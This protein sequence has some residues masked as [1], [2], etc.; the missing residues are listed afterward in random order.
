M[1]DSIRNLFI[2]YV[3]ANIMGMIGLSCYILADT[4]FVARGVGA[5]GLTALNLA[6]PIYSLINGMGLMIGMGGATRF[7]I[8]RD[9]KIFTQ[10]L[11]FVALMTLIFMVSGIFLPG[12]LAGLLGADGATMAYTATYLRVILLFSPMFMMNNLIICFVRND[13]EPKLAMTGMLIGS[14]SNIV[15]DYILVFPLK[16]EMFGAALATGLAPVISLVILSRHFY[17]KKNSFKYVSCPPERRKLMDIAAL[18]SSAFVTEI[19]LGVVILVF[20]FL[21]LRLS[22]NLGVAAYGIIANIGIVISSI[23]TGISQ[24]MQP[25]ISQSYGRGEGENV[26][27]LL[28]YGIVLTLSITVVVYVFFFIFAEP[29]ANLFNKEKNPELTAMAVEG[30]RIYFTA[31]FFAGLNIIGSIY[32]SSVD[33]PKKAFILSILRGLVIIVPMALALSAIWG[34]KG[35]WL[36]LTCTEAIVFLILA[37]FFP[38]RNHNR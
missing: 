28:K 34:M 6:I 37:V 15:L 31:Y 29:A 7:S 14:L 35:I 38:K 32:F 17:K 24:G 10:A 22:G 30:L 3:S 19:S 25:I 12:K 36:S 33:Q 23:F 13:G 9:K 11:Y 8:N 16:M 1:R 18:G 21:I 20:N 27:K 26:K 2:K 4:F 5:D